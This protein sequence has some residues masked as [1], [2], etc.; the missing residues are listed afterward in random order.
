[1][2]LVKSKYYEIVDEIIKNINIDNKICID[3]T[4]G[5]GND[6]LKILSNMKNGLLI[7]FDIQDIALENSK[8]LL[9]K[10]GF[11]NFKL[12]KDSHEN[13]EKYVKEEVEL[14]IF[15]LGYLPAADKNIVTK[16]KS[17][18]NAIKSSLNLLSDTGVVIVV[19]YL[20]HSGSMEERS[21]LEKYLK[22]LD[23][24]KYLVEKRE[25][26]NQVNTPPIIYLLKKRC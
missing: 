20:G 26:F 11:N 21:C 14:V 3:A 18:I 24:N 1:M 19:S 9:E 16:P 17:T 25:F 4:L 13:L 7:G 5:N 10:K 2:I 23:Q 22:T 6:S 8:R 12:I 15:N